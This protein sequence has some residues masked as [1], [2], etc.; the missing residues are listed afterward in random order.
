MA[1]P[2][3][4]Q[5]AS[6]NAAEA[7]TEPRE[8]S[9]ASAASAEQP[10]TAARTYYQPPYDVREAYPRAWTVYDA[11]GKRLIPCGYHQDSTAALAALDDF[12]RQHARDLAHV[13]AILKNPPAAGP[14]DARILAEIRY[15]FSEAKAAETRRTQ[16][17]DAPDAPNANRARYC[18]L[19]ARLVADCPDVRTF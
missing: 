18:Y 9:A 5:P 19:R 11:N 8:A 14:S 16:A 15:W 7:S 2:N 10:E 6:G 12:E 13:L 17:N 4:T 1:T 3:P